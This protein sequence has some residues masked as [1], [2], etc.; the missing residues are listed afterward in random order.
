MD[1]LN[2]LLYYIPYKPPKVDRYI[3]GAS[4]QH[5]HDCTTGQI[6]PRV[7]LLLLSQLLGKMI[8]CIAIV[9]WARLHSRPLQWLLLP[10]QRTG[11]SSSTKRIRINP[12]VHKSLE[13]WTSAAIEKGSSFREHVVTQVP[14][15]GLLDSDDSESEGED[16]AS[17]ASLEPFPSLAPT[18]RDG[19]GPAQP[20]SMEPPSD[21]ATP[22]EQF[23]SDAR[24][25]RRN[26]RAQQRKSWDK[27]KS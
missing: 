22:Q 23:W 25:R 16:L 20:D 6:R 26:R 18:Q 9:P 3:T 4:V 19:E 10:S 11:L 5:S 17:P 8:P 21:L 27:A 2:V 14:G 24:S 1:V 7:P 12:T 13:W 15:P